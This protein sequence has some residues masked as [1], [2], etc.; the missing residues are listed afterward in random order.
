MNRRCHG[1]VWCTVHLVRSGRIFPRPAALLDRTVELAFDDRVLAEQ[2]GALASR[3]ARYVPRTLGLVGVTLAACTLGPF[4]QSACLCMAAGWYG[5]RYPLCKSCLVTGPRYTLTRV[6]GYFGLG[7]VPWLDVGSEKGQCRLS[8]EQ[9]E[10]GEP[11][12]GL[13]EHL[14]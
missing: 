8:L 13:P 11:P 12:P 2:T 9:F 6:Q 4:P 14:T 1:E 3:T 5:P 7:Y 10:Q